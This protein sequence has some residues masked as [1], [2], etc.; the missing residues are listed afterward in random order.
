MRPRRFYRVFRI[1]GQPLRGGH[2]AASSSMF[3]VREHAER[4]RDRLAHD[5][6]LGLGAA[7]DSAERDRFEVREVDAAEQGAWAVDIDGRWKPIPE[8]AP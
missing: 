6:A 4:Q 8:L 3:V 5:Y 2:E 1:F 7:I